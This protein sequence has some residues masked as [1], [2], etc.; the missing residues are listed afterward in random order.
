MTTSGRKLTPEQKAFRRK[1]VVL[2]SA[3]ESLVESGIK[4][5]A[6]LLTGSAGL[7]A[8]CIHSGIDV[9]GSLMVWVGVR[10]APHKFKRFP[11]GFYKIENLLALAIGF[12][13]LYG[14][15]EILQIFLSGESPLPTNIPIGI[16]AVVL[17][18]TLDFFWGRFEARSGRLINSPGIEASGNHTVSDVY[19]SA[20]VLVGLIGSYF[21]FNLDRWAALIVAVLISKM[22]VDILWDNVKVLLDICLSPEQLDSYTKIVSRQPGVQTVK[23]IRGRNAGSFRF[24]DAEIGIKAFS[25]GQANA[26]T[27]KIE[28]VLKEHDDAI[29]TVFVH[30]RHVFPERLRVFVPTDESGQQ[31]SNFFGKSTHFT[32]VEYDRLSRTVV[33]RRTE[34]NQAIEKEKHRGINLAES[35]ID[36][37]A[38]SVCCREDLRDKGPG[39]MFHR[40]GIDVR[41]TGETDL[42]SLMTDYLGNSKFVFKETEE[43]ASD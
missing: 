5:V 18:M 9:V 13:I 6:A 25:V 20:V 38:D 21:G 23:S 22:G 32:V 35:L 27:S 15:Y 12:A 34:P 33:T 26:I 10:L 8:D 43:E 3:A 30:Y 17:G 36:G 40:F 4:L 31:I 28:T 16:G 29:D 1:W 39:L 24:V 41:L 14:A 37:G 11:Y 2:F 7:L 42:D 19:A